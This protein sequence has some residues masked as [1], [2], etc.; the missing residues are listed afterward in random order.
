MKI[1][2]TQGFYAEIDDEDYDVVSGIKWRIRR[3]GESIHAVGWSKGPAKE[4]VMM[5]MHRI[6][7]SKYENI[8]NKIIDHINQNG[9]DNRKK[10]LR[11]A[12]VQQNAF[13]AR[14]H[15]KT[16]VYKGVSRAK[17]NKFQAHIR[18]NNRGIYLGS[19]TDEE[20]AAITYNKKAKELFGV[21]ASLNQIGDKT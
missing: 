15:G 8:K 5:Q 11:L 16:S 21:F 17:K 20:S 18:I 12:T 13:N 10:N 1:P 19:F 9:L 4:R 7:Y 6:I 14:K 2:L 3:G